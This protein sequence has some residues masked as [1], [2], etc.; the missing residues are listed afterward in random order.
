VVLTR[1]GI[2]LVTTA[3]EWWISSGLRVVEVNLVLEALDQFKGSTAATLA[4]GR[5]SLE[6]RK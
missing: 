6:A 5:W 1:A 2:R 3:M 4:L